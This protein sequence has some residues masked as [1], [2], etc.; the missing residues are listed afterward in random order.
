MCVSQFQSYCNVSKFVVD[1]DGFDYNS[2]LLN[3][4]VE[5]KDYRV[6]KDCEGKNYG[7]YYRTDLK[8]MRQLAKQGNEYAKKHLKY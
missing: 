7:K 6:Y 5:V 4:D 3:K 2:D 8:L 1:G